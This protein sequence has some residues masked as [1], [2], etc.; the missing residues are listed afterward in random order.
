MVE[1]NL[2]LVRKLGLTSKD[3][4]TIIALH[5]QREA[6][7]G[8]IKEEFLE[9]GGTDNGRSTFLRVL[10][11]DWTTNQ[12]SLQRAWGFEEDKNYHRFWDLP[13]CLCPKM[14]N[15][16]NYPSGYYYVNFGCPLHGGRV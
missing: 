11:G 1:L 5:V 4:G 12:F 16:D 13:G 3:T 8:M 14:D 7:E 9:E 15:N 2:A 10:L 6:I